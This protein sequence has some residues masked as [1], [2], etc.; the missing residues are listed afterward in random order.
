MLSTVRRP[1]RAKKATL[2]ARARFL[3]KPSVPSARPV[4]LRT[5]LLPRGVALSTLG[6]KGMEVFVLKGKY[7][8]CASTTFRSSGYLPR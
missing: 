3:H 4:G 8:A 1:R 6:R 5:V 7:Q 2:T